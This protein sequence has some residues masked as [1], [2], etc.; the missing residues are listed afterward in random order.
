MSRPRSAFTLGDLL[1]QEDLG[2]E[3]LSGGEASL[4]RR[5]AGAHTIEI[6]HPATW[7]ERDWIMLTTGVRLRQRAEEQRLLIAELDAARAAAVG[8]GVELVFRRVPSALLREA[9]ARSFP[10]FA[11][12]LRTPFREIVSA[13]NR[14]LAGSDLRSM[15]RLSSMQLHLMDAL[16]EE[17][18]QRAVLARLASFVGAT[19]LLFAPDGSVEAATGEAP[20]VAI[21]Q[22]ISAHPA[23]LVEF[24]LDGWHTV[25][26]PVT[27]GQ[28]V[29]GWLAVVSRR[30]RSVDRLIRPAARATA[31]V[32]AALARLRG[33]AREQER[34]IRGALLEQALEPGA[35]SDAGTVAARAASLGIDLAVPARVVLVRS[36]AA[37]ERAHAKADLNDVRARLEHR[38]D[39]SGLRHLTTRRPGAVLA[40]VQGE[41]ER[42][43]AAITGLVDDQP[44]VAAGIGRPVTRLE[45]AVDSLRDAEIAVRRIGQDRR[46]RLL[47]FADFDL[48]T[49]VVSESPAERIQPKVE[50][51]LSI[52]R[53]NPGLHAAL[54]AYFQ[55]GMDVMRAAE[56]MHLHHN[57]VRY[58]LGRL[59][60]LMGR[61]LRDPA[62]IASLYIALAAAPPEL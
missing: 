33:V 31:P 51:C 53:A 38:L 56:A 59:E 48:G 61:Q 20:V 32:L 10:V 24:E 22:A 14:A 52:L 19:T 8:F 34:A 49:L 13:V 27:A 5:V 55:Q 42:L 44:G 54:V 18:P 30:A 62:T 60:Q 11:V 39:D 21:W 36:Q 12:P 50:E 2:L 7:L 25:A 6:E 57:S 47:D 26:T 58:R 9:R 4:E 29:T 37:R 1:A 17:D 46:E 23:V 16:G 28:A 15:Q 40:L 3:L 41:G 43:H 35:G 45:R